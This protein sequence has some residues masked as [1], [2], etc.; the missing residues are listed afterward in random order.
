MNYTNLLT[1]AA[2]AFARD[3]DMAL[4]PRRLRPAELVRLVNSSPLGEV[5]DERR[6][7]E[8]RS[9]AGFRIGDDKSIDLF[10]YVAWLWAERRA[11]RR[12]ADGT[13]QAKKERSRQ[14]SQELVSSGQDIGELPAVQDPGRRA[15]CERN[16]RLAC[17][18]YFALTF[19]IAWSRDHLKAIHKI[20]VSVLEGGLYAL[21][22]PRGSGKTSLAIAA[23][24][25]A[26]LYGHREF[27]ALI[28][29]TEAKAGELLD[30]IRV[31]LE[32][33]ELLLADFPEV[34]FPIRELE[35]VNQRRLRYHGEVI[36]MGFTGKRILLPC[37]PGSKGA[38]GI[39]RVAGITGSIRGMNYK[40][41]DGRTARPSLVIVDDPQT[42]KSAKSPTQNA[43]RE[44]ILAGDILGLAGPGEK[45]CGVMPCTVVLPGDMADNILDRKKHPDWNGERTKMLYAFPTNEKLWEE[46]ARI[47]AE[48]LENDRGGRD[49]TEFYAAN[50]EA[51]DEGADVAWPERHDPDELSG[52]Q[53]AMNKRLLDE[54]AFFAEYQNEP[55]PEQTEEELL[56]VE[57]ITKKVGGLARGKVPIEANHIACFIDVQQ[58]VLFWAVAAWSERFSGQVL[59]YGTYPDQHRTHFGYRDVRHTLGRAHPR[60]GPEGAI[61]AGLSAL[62]ADL[63]ARDW[64]REDGAALRIGVCLVD[65]N[66]QTETILG[67]CRDATHAAVIRP[68]RGRYYGAS[69]KSLNDCEKKPGDLPGLNWRIPAARGRGAVRQVLF[70]T[71]YWKSF[72]QGRL[73][74]D[75]GDRGCL[76]LFAGRPDAHRL[77]AEHLTSEFRVRVESKGKSGRTVDEWKQKPGSPD[78]HWLDCL[79]GCCVG[80]SI[81]GAELLAAAPKPRKSGGRRKWSDMRRERMR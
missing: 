36:T 5:L 47:R 74:A 65:A 62:T 69:S 22:M 19:C 60:K 52:L 25:W 66:W 15:A 30:S 81:L 48:S 27:V 46:Y 53:H 67:F 57:Q 40:R 43:E 23:A 7:R 3:I 63:L 51:M 50:R 18:T 24:I 1:L 75:P 21:A 10:R 58:N 55:I 4:D 45:I 73:A 59:D 42:R 16:F 35:G 29:A 72:L 17:D 26:L 79:V 2:A 49:G 78:N 41:P 6:V 33:N 14:R 20:E 68:A 34:C 8:Q 39:V 80:G 71:N 32:H 11:K 28:A 12:P 38:G 64:Q 31:E 9:R 37:L 61:Y 54:A 13:Y 56:T 77:I 76:L 70:D 44:R